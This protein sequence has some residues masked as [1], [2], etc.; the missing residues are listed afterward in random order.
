MYCIVSHLEEETKCFECD[1]RAKWTE[2]NRNSHRIE[3]IVSS[4]RER[5]IRWWQAENGREQV[6]VQLDLEAE[7]HFT[8]L[9]MTFRTFRP[10]AMLIER[11][12]DFGKTW[13]VY[14]YFAYDCQTSF[15]GVKLWPPQS[16]DEVICENKYSDK[17]PSTEGEVGTILKF[18]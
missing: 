15:P 11:S 17:I 3:N 6:Y 1:S 13:K 2:R 14:R 7:F 4:F 16:M 9:I 18:I 10:R 12:Y 5:K 8:H